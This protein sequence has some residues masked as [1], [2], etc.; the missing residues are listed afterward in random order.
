MEQ[1]RIVTNEQT[2]EKAWWDGQKLTPVRI[3]PGTNMEGMDKGS[4][5]ITDQPP[6]GNLPPP[7]DVMREAG[8]ASGREASEVNAMLTRNV[9]VPLAQTAAG[10]ATGGLSI[11]WQMGLGAA[12]ELGLQEAGLA[13]KSAKGVVAQGLIPGVGNVAARGIKAVGRGI[14]NITGKGQK[15]GEQAI[16]MRLGLSDEQLDPVT[17]AYTEPAS[18]RLY[19]G[20]EAG[21]QINVGTGQAAIQ[22]ALQ[23][24]QALGSQANKSTVKMLQGIETDLAGGTMDAKTAVAK[25][26]RLSGKSSEAFKRGRSTEGATLKEATGRLKDTVPGLKQADEAYTREQAVEE[27][28]RTIRKSNKVKALD[29]LLS[30]PKKGD[31]IKSAIAPDEMRD[32][33]KIASQIVDLGGAGSEAGLTKTGYEG[34]IKS[35]LSDPNGL[36]VFRKSFGPDLGKMTP[37]GIAGL[38]T[39]MRAYQAQT[40]KGK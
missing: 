24:E 37:Q 32:I 30:D 13:P 2:G 22:D 11:P 19:K 17:R 7:P 4:A 23:A 38:L 8:L 28:F 3:N 29:D 14:A 35:F 1:G 27:I 10:V 39:F 18:K 16:G 40:K 34:T 12:L 20:A 25:T 33:R 21:G 5:T 9:A 6:P 31:R 15:A 26:Q 36:T